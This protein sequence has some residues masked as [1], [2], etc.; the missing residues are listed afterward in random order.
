VQPNLAPAD[1]S[2]VVAFPGLLPRGDVAPADVSVIERRTVVSLA[3]LTS[4]DA[5]P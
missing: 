4:A 5:R 1:V 3:P 2:S